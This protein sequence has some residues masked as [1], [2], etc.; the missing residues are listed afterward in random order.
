MQI[1]FAFTCHLF[2]HKI[3]VIQGIVIVGLYHPFVSNHFPWTWRHNCEVLSLGG[4][5]LMQPGFPLMPNADVFTSVKLPRTS[6]IV[7]V[8]AVSNEYTFEILGQDVIIRP[9][10]DFNGNTDCSTTFIAS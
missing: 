5:T 7:G 2:L 9:L 10:L 3:N 4:S 8:I 6:K 1:V